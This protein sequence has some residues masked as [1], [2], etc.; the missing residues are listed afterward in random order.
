MEYV[1]IQ[2]IVARSAQGSDMRITGL[3]FLGLKVGVMPVNVGT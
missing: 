2:S 1:G 3:R